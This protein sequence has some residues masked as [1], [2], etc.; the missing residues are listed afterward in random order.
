LWGHNLKKYLK[1]KD[2]DFLRLHTYEQSGYRCLICGGRGEKWP[3][4]CHEVWD[5]RSFDEKFEAAVLI[6][7]RALCPLCHRVNHLG[8]ANIDGVYE[9]TIVHMAGINQWSIGYAQS[10][11]D[12]A[13]EIWDERS[14][15]NWILGYEDAIQWDPSVKKIL[16]AFFCEKKD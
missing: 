9:E 2:W 5:Y 4:E 6:E 8:K 13:F 15:K 12:D 14:D 7:L 11:A 16:S 1:K 10:I 3:L